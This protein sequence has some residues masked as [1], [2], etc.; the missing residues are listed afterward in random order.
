M[1]LKTELKLNARGLFKVLTW[2]WH[3]YLIEVDCSLGQFKSDKLKGKEYTIN[4]DAINGSKIL[5]LK[6]VE[7]KFLQK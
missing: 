2:L 7:N 5:K 1:K 3:R 4:G 6:T